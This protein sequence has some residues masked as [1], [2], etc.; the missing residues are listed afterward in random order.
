MNF[1]D[2]KCYIF[3]LSQI[4]KANGCYT[5]VVNANKYTA[6]KADKVPKNMI[7]LPLKLAKVYEWDGT[8]WNDVK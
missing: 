5:E 3:Q 2:N 8:S 4:T 6:I 1:I 7:C